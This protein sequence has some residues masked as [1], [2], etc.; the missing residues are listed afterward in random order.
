MNPTERDRTVILLHGLARGPGSMN[1]LAQAL[2]MAGHRVHNLGY[3]STRHPVE[4]L[5]REHL[6][7]ALTACG[8]DGGTLDFVTHSLGGILVRELARACPDLRIGR[9]VMLGPPN[10]GSEI[11]DR[12]GA[13]WLFG[14]INGPAGR[15]LGTGADSLPNRLGPA[16]FALG[17]LAGDRPWLEPFRAWIPGPG[18]GKVSI[19]RTRLAGMHDF[20]VLPVSHAFMMQDPDIIRETVHFLAHGR[21]RDP[22]A[23]P[24]VGEAVPAEQGR[25]P[26]ADRPPARSG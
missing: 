21:F 25:P 7:P 9:V 24:P 16:P 4:V 17:V 18:D 12:F 8:A 14:A 6:R 11:V 22:A 20:R 19:A 26:T 10:L 13:W 23:R 2:T 15:Q 5:V 1:R 3:P